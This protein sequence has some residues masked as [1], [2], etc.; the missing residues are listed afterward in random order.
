MEHQREQPEP[1]DGRREK[2]AADD[3]PTADETGRSPRP[4]QAEGDRETIESDLEDR[5]QDLR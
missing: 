5:E 3:E 1:S 2:A 4:S